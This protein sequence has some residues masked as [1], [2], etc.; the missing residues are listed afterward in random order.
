MT[1]SASISIIIHRIFICCLIFLLGRYHLIATSQQTH[2]ST[3]RFDLNRMNIRSK[4]WLSKDVATSIM[5]EIM[6]E[7]FRLNMNKW[8][9]FIISD[10]HFI[11]NN[12]ASP[13]GFYIQSAEML[14][15][16]LERARNELGHD[17][18]RNH[19][20]L[21][22]CL[23]TKYDAIDIQEFIVWQIM[24]VGIHHLIIYVNDATVDHI[25]QVLEP[26]AKAGYVT[27]ITD[28]TGPGQQNHIYQHC[29]HK[30]KRKACH[31]N[32]YPENRRSR[33]LSTYF[34]D[35]ADCSKDADIDSYQGRERPV[36]MTGIDSD[37]FTTTHD[38]SCFIDH[39]QN[40]SAGNYYGLLLPWYNFGHSNL[41]F[42]SKYSVSTY[43]YRDYR[44]RVGK[45]YNR[46]CF[47]KEMHHSHQ[48]LFPE[49]KSAVNES[50]HPSDWH[51]GPYVLESYPEHFNESGRRSFDWFRRQVLIM[52]SI[53][54]DANRDLTNDISVTATASLLDEIGTAF[55][56]EMDSWSC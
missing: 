7:V 54:R 38:H 2:Q 49:Q 17:C 18:R 20:L 45:S 47:V 15:D 53:A 10:D 19:T 42:S 48:A 32:P 33:D 6:T 28:F 8:F 31:Y 22:A 34:S 36:W 9:S 56:Q 1:P 21:M 44:S 29:V 51:Y 12:P 13:H 46:L 23:I 50:F 11:T 24:I 43:T 26:F 39:L 3:Q 55:D 14:E 25:L 4:L 41:M 27:I 35:T 40:Y 37:E 16:R 30:L 52:L 5:L